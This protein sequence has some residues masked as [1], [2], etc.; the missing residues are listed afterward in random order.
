MRRKISALMIGIVILSVLMIPT[1]LA[2]KPKSVLGTWEWRAP[3]EDVPPG[4]FDVIKVTGDGNVFIHA[5]D[6]ARFT[7]TFE[8]TGY[9]VFKITIHPDGFATG[10]GRTE[11]TGEVDEKPGTLEIM[12][13]GKTK[14][15]DAEDAWWW[16]FKWVI[17]SGTG[18]L[19]NL[20]GQGTCWG[21]GPEGPYM[22]YGGVVMTGTIHFDPS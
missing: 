13:V 17:I 3:S 20:R 22:G 1:V 19:A 5:D 4:F 2:T 21:P 14:W 8:G 12:W 10:S 18:E 15:N 6:D 11:F 7:G 9:D 16:S